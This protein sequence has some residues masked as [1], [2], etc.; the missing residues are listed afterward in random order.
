MIRSPF[1]TWCRDHRGSRKFLSDR[2]IGVVRHREG[3][4]S[5]SSMKDSALGTVS[6]L[7]TPMTRIFD[8]APPASSCRWTAAASGGSSSWQLAHQSPKNRRTVRAS[9]FRLRGRGRQPARPTGPTSGALNDGTMSPGRGRPPSHRPMT[10]TT[11]GTDAGGSSPTPSA[12]VATMPTT[13]K[14]SARSAR[15]RIGFRNGTR[16][17][18]GRRHRWCGVR[19]RGGGQR[20]TP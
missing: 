5:E 1:T 4:S 11:A 10:R 9:R 15:S 16:R 20:R 7:S 3:H 12:T 6:S 19:H 14:I 13:R 18:R 8:S 17:R 2:D